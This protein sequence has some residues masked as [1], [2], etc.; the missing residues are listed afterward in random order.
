M[1]RPTAYTAFATLLGDE[2][3]PG[4]SLWD[5]PELMDV[6]DM[7]REVRQHPGFVALQTLI[8]AH[9][10]KLNDEVVMRPHRDPLQNA[11]RTGVVAGIRSVREAAAAVLYAAWAR[12]Q[13]ERERE[14]A[15]I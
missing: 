3:A 9:E 7:V 15:E 5:T 14:K 4:A 1:E 11:R 10:R 6:A 2:N 8:E 13:A 12:E